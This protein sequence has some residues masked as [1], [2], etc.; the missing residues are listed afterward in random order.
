MSFA[1][2]RVLS[3]ESRRA[4]DMH[5]L[6]L[7]E[8]GEPF[9][10]PS[11]KEQ[12]VDDADI[13]LHFVEQLERGEFDMLVCMT[14]VGL[15]LL[16]DTCAA[17]MPLERLGAALRKA[18]IVSRG[19]KPVG[20]LRAL[21]VPIEVMIPEPNTWREIVTAVAPRP[22]R[23]IAIQEYGR[24]NTQLKVA[25][26]ELGA[27][28]T[29]VALYRWE[30][31]DNLE[32]LREAVDRIRR[33]ACEVVLFTSSVQL[34]HLLAIAKTMDAETEVRAALAERVVVASIGPVMSDA[35]AAEGIAPDVTPRHPKMWALV[36]AAAEESVAVLSGAKR[37]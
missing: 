27:R 17:R 5:T 1:G 35:L 34:D 37:G 36:K 20:L 21:G 15:V 32:P 29:P 26:E 24:T 9:I 30:L 22:E 33:R 31:P 7:R 2:L 8:G 4:Q 10:A 6:I 13:A 12:A 3:L 11:V 19:P 18:T 16:R 14:G 28:V 23:R 25:L